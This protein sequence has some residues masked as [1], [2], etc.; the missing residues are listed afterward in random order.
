MSEYFDNSLLFPIIYN[1]YNYFD[2]ASSYLS[3]KWREYYQGDVWLYQDTVIF[4]NDQWLGIYL[5]PNLDFREGI[6]YVILDDKDNYP[7]Q[8]RY[9]PNQ[10]F[11]H[12][13]YYRLIKLERLDQSDDWQSLL[14]PQFIK[15]LDKTGF[16]SPQSAIEIIVNRYGG[17][18]GDSLEKITKIDKLVEYTDKELLSVFINH[19]ISIKLTFENTILDDIVVYVG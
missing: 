1:L 9:L 10:H 13:E 8:L 14:N 17:L 19:N 2:I 15:Y 11:D 6:R 12:R 18:D 3:S 4:N 5:Q 16:D 7:T